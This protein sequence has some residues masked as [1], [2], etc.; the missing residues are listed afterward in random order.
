MDVGKRK[1][2][3]EPLEIKIME[4][5]DPLKQEFLDLMKVIG[6]TQA[7]AARQLAMTSGAVNQLVNPNSPVRPSQTTLRLFKLIVA[8]QRPEAINAK[9]LELKADPEAA[10]S[11]PER[12]L[13]EAL[14]KIPAA[15]VPRAY[16]VV[17]GVINGFG[18]PLSLRRTRQLRQ[19][20]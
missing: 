18:A 5:L 10:L 20:R 13:I 2:G 14:R 8:S 15:E 16:A 4:P 12:K 6:W 11:L 19:G 3:G 9:T 1:N 17:H 7:E